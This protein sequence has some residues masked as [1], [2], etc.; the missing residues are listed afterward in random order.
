[1]VMALR[2]ADEDDARRWAGL[3]SLGCS[4]IGGAIL[5]DAD[6]VVL[7]VAQTATGK[8]YMTRVV[9]ALQD[10]APDLQVVC[11]VR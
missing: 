8:A 11:R 9:E 5:R 4:T 2:F 10:E 7:V 3:A 1:M 6:V